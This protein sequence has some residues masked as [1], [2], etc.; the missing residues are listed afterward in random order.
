M[1]FDVL[2]TIVGEIADQNEA[3][4]LAHEIEA[5]VTR[6]RALGCIVQIRDARLNREVER[7]VA[8]PHA[9]ERE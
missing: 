4:R 1:A 7:I 9:L 5:V 6:A 3:E 2:A 8:L